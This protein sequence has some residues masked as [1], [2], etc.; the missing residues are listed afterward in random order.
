Q[1]ACL[2][3]C[4]SHLYSRPY[5][6][7]PFHLSLSSGFGEKNEMGE[8]AAF[9]GSFPLS[10]KAKKKGGYGTSKSTDGTK[11]PVKYPRV[12][13]LRLYSFKCLLLFAL[14]LIK[15]HLL[16]QIL[17]PPAF[18]SSRKGPKSKSNG[19]KSQDA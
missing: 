14:L 7:I 9:Q 19:P 2:K 18:I 10:I 5:S 6:R 13:R 15:A 8:I 1:I 4:H 3:P 11:K 12:S 17:Q 16:A